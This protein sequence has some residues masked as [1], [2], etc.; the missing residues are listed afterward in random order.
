MS[1]CVRLRL[2]RSE[3]SLVAS[4]SLLCDTNG[5][6]MH[7]VNALPFE[8]GNIQFANTI[9]VVRKRSTLYD[10]VPLGVL[11]YTSTINSFH[12]SLAFSLM[13]STAT[14]IVVCFIASNKYNGV[15]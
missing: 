9:G 1:N 15:V 11:L 13:S 5:M 10:R 7:L 12:V 14:G 8:F 6:T 2:V 4:G 3:Y